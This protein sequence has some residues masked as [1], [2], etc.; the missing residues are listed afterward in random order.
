MIY[1]NTDSAFDSL[2]IILNNSNYQYSDL[3]KMY[4]VDFYKI[5]RKIEQKL[6]KQSK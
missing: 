5:L 6:R 1:K 4:V 2:D 3:K